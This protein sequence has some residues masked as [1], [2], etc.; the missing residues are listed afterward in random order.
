MRIFDRVHRDRWAGAAA[1]V[2]PPA[3]AAVF[4]PWRSSLAN[5]DMALLLVAV[6]VAVAANGHRVAGIVAAASAALWFDFFWTVP[7]ERFSITRSTDIQTTVLLLAVG[8]AVSE[9]AFRAR[10]ARRTVVYDTAYQAELRSTARLVADERDPQ[11]VAEHVRSQ[12]V[13]LL[14][15]RNARFE[16]GRM[17]GHPPRLADDG[18]LVWEGRRWNVDEYGFPDTEIELRARSGGRTLGRF[19]LTP[20]PGTVPSLA[21]RQVAAML[22]AQ[23]GTALARDAAPLQVTA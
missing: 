2:V 4:L 20:V 5:T 6:V 21:A 19:M 8:A 22:A 11:A 3:V 1:L 16:A 17:L 15:L 7:Y 14:G 10:R 23:A 9:L 18:T 13:M 12:L